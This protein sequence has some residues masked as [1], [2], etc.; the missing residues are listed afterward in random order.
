M[1]LRYFDG[2]QPTTKWE[3]VLYVDQRA[4]EA[5]LAAIS[6]IY[7]G[8]VGGRVMELYGPAI[9]D[10]HAVRRARITVEHVAARKRI[11]VVGYVTLQAQG[12]A[13]E[14]GDVRCGIPGYD[15]PGTELFGDGLTSSDPLLR[16]EVRGKRHA[17]FATDF[18][19]ASNT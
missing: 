4:T 10:V 18:D 7:L 16:F 6:D 19:Y 17:S 15:H 3:V 5:Q 14:E 13:S 12:A 1:T 2:R 8:R 11:D 9:G